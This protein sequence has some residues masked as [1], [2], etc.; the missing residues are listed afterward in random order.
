ML[1]DIP[2]RGFKQIS[3]HGVFWVELLHLKV[4]YFYRL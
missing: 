3:E 1:A 4:N 2:Y